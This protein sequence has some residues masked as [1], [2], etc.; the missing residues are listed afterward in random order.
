[1]D[2]SFAIVSL[3]ELESIR[4]GLNQKGFKQSP[5]D[6]VICRFRYKGIKVDVMSTKEVGWAPW[7]KYLMN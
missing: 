7:P 5:E 4:E 6:N 3:G 2:I 1:V